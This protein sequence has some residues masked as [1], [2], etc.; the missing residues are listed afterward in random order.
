MSITG[1]IFI[2]L[3]ALLPLAAIV[4]LFVLIVKALKKYIHSGE[5]R[6][7]KA[8]FQKSLGEVLKDHRTRCKMTQELVAESLGVSR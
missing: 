3:L 8:L 2:L 4:Y 5:A 6:Q 7:E 1:I